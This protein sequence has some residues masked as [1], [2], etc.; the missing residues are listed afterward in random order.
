[1]LEFALT[2]PYAPFTIAFLVM[3]GIGLIEAIGLGLGS[4]DIDV[5][6]DG[7]FDGGS[8]LAWLGLGG[9]MPILIWIT[10][11]L[12]CFVLAGFG[13]QQGAEALWDAPLPWLTAVTAAAPAALVLNLFAANVL[14][15]VLPKEETTAIHLDELVGMRVTVLE[16]AATRGRP[17]RGKVVDRFGQPHYVM[18]EPDGD[19]PIP[20][21]SGG[22]IVARH[23]GAFVAAP[24]ID[25]MLGPVA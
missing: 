19:V 10:S 15:R 5:D 2:E 7:H 6:V 22:V 12:A 3:C 25:I 21:G 14:H 17:S 4:L 8:A 1:M 16:Y 11:L 23:P 24:D 18:V 20:A 13:I 9:G